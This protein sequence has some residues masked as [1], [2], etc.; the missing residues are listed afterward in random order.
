MKG[1]EAIFQKERLREIRELVARQG[2]AT[3]EELSARFGLSAVTIRKDLA[4]LEK[5]GDLVRTHGGAIAAEATARG[6]T[7]ASRLA[8]RQPEKQR[9][10]RA[11]ASMVSDGEVVFLDA[12]TTVYGMC[13][14]LAERHALTVVTLGLN[15]AYWLAANSDATIILIGGTLRRS[16]YGM[17]SALREDELRSWNIGKAFVGLWGLSIGEGLTDTPKEL[18]AQKRVICR[19]AREVIALADSSKWGKVSLESFCGMKDVKKVITDAKASRAMTED[20][21]AMGVEVIRT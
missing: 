5:A 1:G 19:H 16:S 13:T 8:E 11:A 12:S 10:S 20:L 14:H 6:S 3:V 18:V 4:E 2:R 17:L 7:F 21:R 15:M 9:I